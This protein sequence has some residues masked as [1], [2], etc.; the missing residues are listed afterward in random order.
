MTIPEQLIIIA[1]KL[2]DNDIKTFRRVDLRDAGNISQE[3]WQGSYSPTFQSMNKDLK[4][5][6]PSAE[7]Y[8]KKVFCYANK[9]L[10]THQLTTY[11]YELY[12]DMKE[13]LL[14]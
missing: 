1:G 13:V 12:R 11:G 3:D 7:M 4:G 2:Y 9:Q 14:T 8:R 10:H 6:P 5:G